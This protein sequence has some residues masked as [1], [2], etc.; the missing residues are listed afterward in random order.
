MSDCSHWHYVFTC[1]HKLG[2]MSLLQNV[3]TA[4]FHVSFSFYLRLL[5]LPLLN[6]EIMQKLWLHSGTAL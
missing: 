5:Q 2:Y 3:I 1:N 4:K 6:I